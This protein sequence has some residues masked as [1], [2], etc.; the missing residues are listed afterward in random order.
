M[1]FNCNILLECAR[2]I[3]LLTPAK[4]E[5]GNVDHALLDKRMMLILA[6]AFSFLLSSAAAA[7]FS[8]AATVILLS[9]GLGLLGAIPVDRWMSEKNT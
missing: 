2:L 5:S 4:M 6:T 9:T 1:Q 7:P 3:P 8:I